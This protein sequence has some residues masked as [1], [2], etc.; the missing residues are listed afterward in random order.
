MSF[1]GTMLSYVA[2]PYQMYQLTHSSFAVGLLGLVEL[3]P[4]LLTAF[5]GAAW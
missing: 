5:V 1:L 3:V 4:L 2:L